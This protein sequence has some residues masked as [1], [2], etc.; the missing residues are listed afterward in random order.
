M[1]KILKTALYSI[2]LLMLSACLKDSS[3]DGNLSYVFIPSGLS[4]SLSPTASASGQVVTP[5]SDGSI[6]WTSGTLNVAKIQF[7]GK[8]DQSSVNIEYTNLSVVSVLSLAA[9]AGSVTL[10]AGTY[11]D[12]QLKAN[13]VESAVNVPLILKGTYKEAN[14][15]AAIPV[16]FQFNENLELKV[17]PPQIVIQGDQ[18]TANL[19]LQI[20]KLVTNLTASDFGQTVRTQ[21]NNTILVTKTLNPALY[22]KLRNNLSSTIKVDIVHQ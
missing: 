14:G 2:S 20:N 3:N 7:S 15:G 4:A 1:K 19:G 9:A 11:G 17:N 6:T 5:L 16:E 21:P 18:Y 12:I 13:L 10:P 8:K 22:E